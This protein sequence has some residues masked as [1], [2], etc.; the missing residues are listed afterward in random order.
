MR[1][2]FDRQF[3][4][5]GIRSSLW[6]LE[7]IQAQALSLARAELVCGLPKITVKKIIFCSFIPLESVKEEIL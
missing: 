6:L 4:K 3:Q 1:S 2:F 5:C 7:V